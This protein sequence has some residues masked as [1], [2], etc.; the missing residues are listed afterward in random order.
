MVR[1]V[2]GRRLDGKTG[3]TDP[4]QRLHDWIHLGPWEFDADFERLDR[5]IDGRDT[6]PVQARGFEK[7]RKNSRLAVS[8]TSYQRSVSIRLMSRGGMILNSEFEDRLRWLAI[9]SRAL[10]RDARCFGEKL[11]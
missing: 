7:A 5:T 6:N 11:G 9:S 8:Y 10:V 3:R 2:A 1:P 4:P